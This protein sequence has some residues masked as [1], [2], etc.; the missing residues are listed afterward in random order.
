MKKADAIFYN[1]IQWFNNNRSFFINYIIWIDQK[2]STQGKH[3]YVRISNEL[4]LTAI[5]LAVDSGSIEVLVITK[6][7]LLVYHLKIGI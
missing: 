1:I 3:D 4:G 2:A 6:S 5:H 7:Y